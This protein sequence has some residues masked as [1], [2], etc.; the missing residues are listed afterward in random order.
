MA[1]PD[2]SKQIFHQTSW[3]IIII[4]IIIIISKQKTTATDKT[5]LQGAAKK[6]NPL[7]YFAN[8]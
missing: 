6:S 7:A 3:Y 5:S 8:F 4:I 2:H 1:V